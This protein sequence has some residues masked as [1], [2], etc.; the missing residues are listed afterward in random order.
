MALNH[1]PLH[2]KICLEVQQLIFDKRAR[3]GNR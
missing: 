1:E 3:E 2:L